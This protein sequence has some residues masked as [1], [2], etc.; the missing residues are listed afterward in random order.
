MRMVQPKLDKVK[1]EWN[2][3]R[4]R[5]SRY[6]KVAGIPDETYFLR[7]IVLSTEKINFILDERDINYE[8]HCLLYTC[9]DF[10][11]QY[12]TYVIELLGITMPPK[13]WAEARKIYDVTVSSSS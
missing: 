6:V 7:G 1:E 3:H 4:V 10:L 11:Q 9:D 8:A 2:P 5:H 12:F 13:D